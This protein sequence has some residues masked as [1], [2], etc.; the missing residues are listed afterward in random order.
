MF[1][2][3]FQ[4]YLSKYLPLTDEKSPGDQIPEHGSGKSW[5]I[6]EE[7]SQRYDAHMT[8]DNALY[9]EGASFSADKHLLKHI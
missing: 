3:I 1:P 5:S 2:A 7:N 9:V 8:E 6:Q 4:S